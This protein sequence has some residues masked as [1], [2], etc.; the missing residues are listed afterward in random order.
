MDD[1]PAVGDCF[2]S[3]AQGVAADARL[4]QEQ[5]QVGP[6]G[7]RVGV[8]LRRAPEKRDR[9]DV[10]TFTG[11]EKRQV[12]KDANK[13]SW[14]PLGEGMSIRERVIATALSQLASQVYYR[15]S[16]TFGIK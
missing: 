8:D 12:K 6:D 5:G 3:K 10:V 16:R 1:V 11:M 7:I 15:Y 4:Q 9:L 13:G 2:P 14:D